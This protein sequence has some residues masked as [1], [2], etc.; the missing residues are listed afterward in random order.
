MKSKPSP[1]LPMSY[2][3]FPERV[4]TS[5]IRLSH[6][7]GV[8]RTRGNFNFDGTTEKESGEWGRDPQGA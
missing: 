6:S 4:F 8:L 3:T 2:S 1:F 7:F 5:L